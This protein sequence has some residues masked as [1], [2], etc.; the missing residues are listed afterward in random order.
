MLGYPPNP[1]PPPPSAGFGKPPH[2]LGVCIWMHLVNG[3]GNSPVFGTAD[4]RSSQTSAMGGGGTNKI[5]A[6][7]WDPIFCNPPPHPGP[8]NVP[9]SPPQSKFLVAFEWL[10][11]VSISRATDLSFSPPSLPPSL[12]PPS[13]WSGPLDGFATLCLASSPRVSTDG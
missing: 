11:C 4:P 13:L 6:W 1:P 2:G 5:G 12:L 7:A 10:S 8:R 9:P 3:T